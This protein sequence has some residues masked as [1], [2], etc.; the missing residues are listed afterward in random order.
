M[1]PM[2]FL[3][4]LGLVLLTGADAM[5]QEADPPRRPPSLAPT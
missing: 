3:A 4:L 1:I 5:A 2:I